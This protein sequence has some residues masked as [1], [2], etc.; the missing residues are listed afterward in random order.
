MSLT[1]PLPA[2]PGTLAEGAWQ[3][4][5][6]RAA[7]RLGFPVGGTT[8]QRAAAGNGQLNSE[9]PDVH[10]CQAGM[11]LGSAADCATWDYGSGVKRRTSTGWAWSRCRR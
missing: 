4:G 6:R 10:P 9:A 11:P 1:R 2:G 3:A 8:W 5:R 7:G